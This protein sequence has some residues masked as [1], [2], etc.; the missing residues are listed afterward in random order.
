MLP[1]ANKGPIRSL[2]RRHFLQIGAGSAM[3]TAW[4]LNGCMSPMAATG[5]PGN[6]LSTT[7]SS[8]APTGMLRVALAAV[9]DSL[10]PALFVTSAAF[11]FGFVVDDGLV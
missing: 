1:N 2:S 5:A 4:F 11:H 3:T 6:G 7:A 9:P 8:T 10:D